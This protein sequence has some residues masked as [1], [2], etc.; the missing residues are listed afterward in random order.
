MN[1]GDIIL[2]TF[3]FSDLT[4]TKIRPALAVQLGFVPQP[5][6]HDYMTEK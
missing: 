1:R 3:P 5:N 6:L 2:I 4:S